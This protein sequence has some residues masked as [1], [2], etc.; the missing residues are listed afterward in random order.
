[1]YWKRAAGEKYHLKI[2]RGRDSEDRSGRE[3][4]ERLDFGDSFSLVSE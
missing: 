3:D 1:M 2:K 4:V